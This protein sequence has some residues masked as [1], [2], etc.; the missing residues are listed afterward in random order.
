M[1]EVFNLRFYLDRQEIPETHTTISVWKTISNLIPGGAWLAGG[2]VTSL[3]R[4][5]NNS[6]DYDVFFNSE[7]S[8]LQLKNNLDNMEEATL[9]STTDKSFLYQYAGN[10]INVIRRQYYPS[11]E[12]LFADFDI[13]ICMFALDT[14]PFNAMN[15]YCGNLSLL[16]L[17]NKE[18]RINNI[19]QLGSTFKRVIKYGAKGFTVPKDTYE[20]LGEVFV[21][22]SGT[23][24]FTGVSPRIHSG[25]S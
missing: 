17:A 15:L 7:A 5:A 1:T 10:L 11:I 9:I 21:K 3:L 4:N 20:K 6:N 2:A 25:D 14:Q 23:K 12:A 18:I 13:T 16:D 8:M 22:A 24:V 19:N